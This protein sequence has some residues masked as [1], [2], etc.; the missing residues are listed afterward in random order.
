MAL[1]EKTHILQSSNAKTQYITIPA[2]VVR[3]SQYPFREDDEVEIE[4]LPAQIGEMSHN[5][6]PPRHVDQPPAMIPPAM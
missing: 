6:S 2:A 3:D 5:A 1:K 4:V